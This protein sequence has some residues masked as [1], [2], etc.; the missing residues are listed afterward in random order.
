MKYVVRDT[1]L[2]K[3]VLWVVVSSGIGKNDLV[4]GTKW[5]VLFEENVKWLSTMVLKILFQIDF[6]SRDT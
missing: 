4:P 5:V 2:L 3:P 1:K 6:D